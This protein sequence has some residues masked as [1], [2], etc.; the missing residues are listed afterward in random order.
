MT[1][2]EA[3]AAL[4]RAERLYDQTQI[5]MALDRMAAQISGDMEC[6]N[7]VT[8]C[9]MNGGLI[10]AGHLFTRLNFPM[11]IDYLHVT[12]YRSQLDGGELV[13]N[14]KPN[15]ALKGR[16]VLVIDDILDEGHTLA[17]ILEYCRTQAA[18]RVA[19]A[20]LVDKRHARKHPGAHADYLGLCVD[21]RYVFGFGMDYRGYLR[22]LPAIYAAA[23][24]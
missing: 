11:Q 10:I 7:P 6:A 15:L 3:T 17:A 13:W 22:N 9:V 12:R 2:E 19:A 20:V 5:E 23:E 16:A 4:A 8:L 24:R 1:P 18:E 14:R 21:D